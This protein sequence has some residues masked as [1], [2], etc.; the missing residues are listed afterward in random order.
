MRRILIIVGILLLPIIAV[1]LVVTGVIGKKPITAAKVTLTVWGTEDTAKAYTSAI[2]KYTATRPYATITY[3][4]VRTEDYYDQ[5]LAAWARGTGPDVFFVPN[6]WVGKMSEFAEPMPA[7]STVPVVTVKNGL[8]GKQSSVTLAPQTP[9]SLATL[10]QTYID[11]VLTDA[12]RDGRLWGLPLSMDTV[13]LYYNQAL[14]NNAR[15]FEPAS[16][17]ADFVSQ[18]KANQLTVVDSNNAIVRSAAPLGTADNVPYSTDI[19][20]LLMQQNGAKMINGDRA[21]F[22]DANGLSA[23]DFYTSFAKES[24]ETY[25]WNAQQPNALEAFLAGK[26]VYYFGTYADRATIAASR[27]QWGV[28]PMLQIDRSQTAQQIDIARYQIG[29]VAKASKTAKR[30]NNAW[31]LLTFMARSDNVPAYLKATGKL[32]AQKKLLSAQKDDPSLGVY[33]SQLLTARSWYTG[34]GGPVVDEYFRAMIT[35]VATG[36]ASAQD[37]LKLTVNQITSTL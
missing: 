24:K 32:S 18:I 22:G 30:L 17:W 3:K 4:Q 12:Y 16:T 23:L 5:L 7:T 1:V 6:S 36:Q 19:L 13:V 20:A 37:A 10:K 25:S 35:S 9:P 2:A 14:L 11:A 27:L 15:I 29:M 21:A 31:N 28:A 33:A 34:K 26:A 8:F